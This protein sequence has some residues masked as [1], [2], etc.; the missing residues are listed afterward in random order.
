[1]GLGHPIP[2]PLSDPLASAPRSTGSSPQTM[3]T[4]TSTNAADVSRTDRKLTA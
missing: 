1:M 4:V 3:C 2:D